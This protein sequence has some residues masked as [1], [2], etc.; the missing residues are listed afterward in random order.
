MVYGCSSKVQK[1]GC[2]N[3]V[4]IGIDISLTI[5]EKAGTGYYTSNLV[6]ALAKI[7][8]KNQYTLYPF[9]YYIYHPDFKCAQ[10][11]LKNNFHI[12]F[13]RL[14]KRIIDYLWTSGVPKKWILG[15][16]DILHSTSFCAPKN[17][18]GKLIVTIYDLSFLTHPQ[19]H[20]EAN[21]KHCLQGTIDSIKHADIIIAIS[22]HG[23]KEILKYFDINEA[24]IKVIHLAANDIFKP[25]D[26]EAKKAVLEKYDISQ[27][28]IFNLGTLE[29]RKNIKT[30]IE[31]YARLLSIVKSKN[32]LVIGGGRGWLHSEIDKLVKS[33]NLQQYIK[34]IGYVKE[35]DLPALYSAAKLFVY[36]SLYEG[37]GLP[38]LEAMAC[39]TPVITSNS[40]SLPEIAGDAA[41]LVEPTDN[42]QLADYILKLIDDEKLRHQMSSKGLE[43]AKKFSW[44]KTARETLDIYEKTYQL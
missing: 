4:K 37:F 26:E 2:E 42:R 9:F 35:E 19:C 23:K 39:G 8:S 12:K 22:H 32:L 5:G 30:L 38:V 34:F 15:E 24:K 16:V 29:P 41:L 21:R 7:D 25:K 44:G 43:Q 3:M 1:L 20:V 13:E 14:P 28:Y 31:A 33:L 17:H 11:P 40:S 6:D 18:Y 27:D 10:K 36:P